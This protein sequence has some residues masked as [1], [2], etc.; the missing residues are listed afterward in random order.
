MFLRH[1]INNYKIRYL[2]SYVTLIGFVKHTQRKTFDNSE[3]E[4][5]WRL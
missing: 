1:Q 2:R 4:H 3:L 5:N